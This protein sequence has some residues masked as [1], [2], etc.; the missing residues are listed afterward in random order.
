MNV[1]NGKQNVQIGQFQEFAS[2]L[3]TE[4]SFDFNSNPI[5]ITNQSGDPLLQIVVDAGLIK[6]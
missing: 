5:I 1:T 2:K 6:Y 3:D 4:I